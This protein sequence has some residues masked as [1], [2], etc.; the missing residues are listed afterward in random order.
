MIN[1]LYV[2]CNASF[3]NMSSFSNSEIWKLK[4]TSVKNQLTV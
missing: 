1:G 3:C 4:F 2:L